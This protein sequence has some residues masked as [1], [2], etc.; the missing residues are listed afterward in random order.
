M[1]SRCDKGIKTWTHLYQSLG[2]FTLSGI[3]PARRG[4]P[5]IEV[6]FDIDANGIIKVCKTIN[7]QSQV[8]FHLL[9]YLQTDA[10]SVVHQTTGKKSDAPEWIFNEVSYLIYQALDLCQYFWIAWY[11]RPLWWRTTLIDAKE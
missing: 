3:E 9:K 1:E 4:V 2:V 10:I 5:Q 11:L 6:T 7:K 8:C